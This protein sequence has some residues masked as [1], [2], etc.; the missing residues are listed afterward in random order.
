MTTNS[1]CASSSTE[2]LSGRR[3]VLRHLIPDSSALYG[4]AVLSGVT[5][6]LMLT[7]P[8]F[9]LQVYD[10]V[11]PS[12]S[13]PTLLTLLSLV[14]ALYL[15][16]S[17]I[18]YCRGRVLARLSEALDEKLVTRLFSK[19]LDRA[20]SDPAKRNSPLNELAVLRRFLSGAGPSALLDAPWIPIYLVI[21]ASLHWMLGLFGL[22]GS[23]VVVSLAVLADFATRS[24][25]KKSSEI[26][27]AAQRLLVSMNRA[28]EAAKVL[29]MGVRLSQRYAALRSDG[30]AAEAG[31]GDT[32]ARFSA[33]SKGFRMFLQSA[34]LAA[35]AALAI[36]QEVSAGAI[37]ASS[38]ILGRALA[39][40]DQIVAQWR[41]ISQARDA[42]DQIAT[43]LTEDAGQPIAISLAPPLGNLKVDGLVAGPPGSRKPVLSGVSFVLA[44]GDGL[45][46]IGP[47]GSGK[48]T[49]ARALVGTTV[50]LAGEIRLDGATLDQWT[51]EALGRHIGYLPQDTELFDGTI[52]E[53]IARHDPLARDEDVLRAAHMA[54]A[55]EMI[56]SLPDG[57][58]YNVGE[59]GATMSG[60]QRQRIA[61]A[62]A[63]YGDPVLIVL[64][65][66]NANLDQ[67]G[68][69]ALTHAI[70]QARAR[71][72]TVVVITH[73]PSAVA[74]VD[75]IL[76]L[77]DG[78]QAGFNKKEVI[79]GQVLKVAAESQSARTTSQ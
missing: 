6:L 54:G 52:H 22:F 73:R 20:I 36:A 42:F 65:E 55:H 3:A 46:I 21:L 67:E 7:A 69:A 68:D 49:L 61:L 79:L 75:L 37:V 48:S 58:G 9:M 14:A 59:G 12:G 78:E 29:G 17:I 30:I 77:K 26:E 25:L 34:I 32:G 35:G 2:S 64:D 71:G 19:D 41:S 47:S 8:L 44:P 62:R 70:H 39:P 40:I 50:P 31:S 24:N 74:A 13:I 66:P 72:A 1:H 10:R 76:V 27:P 15:A 60:G 38:I 4:V 45:G 63:L 5:N 23:I 56:L 33:F 51:P 57:Y 16:Q 28:A 11:I 43:A 53:C 18:D